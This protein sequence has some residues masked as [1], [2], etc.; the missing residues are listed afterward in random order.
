MA[1]GG[2]D[3]GDGQWRE[4]VGHFIALAKEGKVD[5]VNDMIHDEEDHQGLIVAYDEEGMTALMAAAAMG[6]TP[7]VLLLLEYGAVWYAQ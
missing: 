2:V 7:C 6:S 5:E 1:A 3:D 4:R